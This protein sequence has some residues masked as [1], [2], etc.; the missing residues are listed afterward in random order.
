MHAPPQTL[1]I[2]PDRLLKKYALPSTGEPQSTYP[3]P[4]Q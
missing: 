4:P 3:T 2:R 1:M